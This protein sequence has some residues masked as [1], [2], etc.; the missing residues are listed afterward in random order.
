M[1]R[2]VDKPEF[3]KPRIDE[4]I[5]QNNLR[6]SIWAGVTDEV[7][8]AMDSLHK[9]ILDH[10][11]MPQHSVIDVGCAYGHLLELMPLNW[12]GEY[13]GIDISKDFLRLAC[14][15]YP[16]HHWMV[17]DARELTVESEYDRFD[18]AVCRM[19]WD[20]TRYSLGEEEWTKFEEKLKK[21]ARRILILEPSKENCRVIE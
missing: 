11:I 13:L 17:A 5:K 20:M 21:I 12:R 1:N 3:W 9:I 15:H 6:H 7:W 2:P 14:I 8:N 10:V 18:W 4:A 16:R 19:V